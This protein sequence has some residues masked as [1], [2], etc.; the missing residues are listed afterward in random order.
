MRACLSL[1]SARLAA[2]V[3]RILELNLGGTA[4]GTGINADPKYVESKP[5]IA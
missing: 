3:E 1:I 5:S 4:V 2:A